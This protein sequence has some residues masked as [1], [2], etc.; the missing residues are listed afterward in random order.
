MHNQISHTQA[1]PKEA[2]EKHIKPAACMQVLCCTPRAT[3]GVPSPVSS[4]ACCPATCSQ[5]A[6]GL[7]CCAAPC[8]RTRGSLPAAQGSPRAE[9]RARQREP[10]SRTVSRPYLE[11][12]TSRSASEG[13]PPLLSGGSCACRRV[14]RPWARAQETSAGSA[15][16]GEVGSVTPQVVGRDPEAGCTS[17]VGSQLAVNLQ[18]LPGLGPNRMHAHVLPFNT[19]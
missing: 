5:A 17:I 6:C 12:P 4:Q 15:L 16:G 14:D 10:N 3:F 11:A 8:V 19:P 1:S 13:C 7:R 2:T 18:S 9:P